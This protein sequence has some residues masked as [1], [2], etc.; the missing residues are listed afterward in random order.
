MNTSPSSRMSEE[1]YVEQGG[2]MCP[3]CRSDQVEGYDVTV[4]E[5]HV[6]QKISCA[7]IGEQFWSVTTRG[8]CH[9][10]GVCDG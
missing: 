7:G 9:R 2:T 10:K 4:D 6:R 1:T 8:T 3:F 5:A